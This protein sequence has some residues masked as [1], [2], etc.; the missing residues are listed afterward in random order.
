MVGIA[1]EQLRYSVHGG[2]GWVARTGS[3]RD[4]REHVWAAFGASTEHGRLRSVLMHRPGPEIDAVTNVSEALWVASPNAE[5]ARMQ[6]DVL[7]DTYRAHE[8][9]VH[10]VQDEC[11]AHPNLVFMRDSYAMSPEGAILARPASRVRAGEERV[12]ARALAQLGIPIVLSVYG[13]GT[14]EGGDLMMVNENLALIGV[15]LRTNKVGAGQVEQ[16]LRSIGIAEV[17]HVPVDEHIIHLDCAYNIVAA[18]VAL[19]H[20]SHRLPAAE[21]ALRRHGFRMVELPELPETALGLALNVVAIQPGLV[22]MP[23]GCP[24]TRQMIGA[25]GVDCC[26]VEISELMKG[27]GAVHCVTGVLHRDG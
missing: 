26:E 3:L 5:M 21:A 25:A 24:E 18:D 7:A 2:H 20:A 19:C 11:H 6:H 15:G 27:G 23:A 10:Y 16:L 8:V 1:R 22:L 4:E 14:F 12:V 17:V 13:W 9:A